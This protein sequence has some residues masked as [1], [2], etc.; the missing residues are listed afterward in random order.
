MAEK[1]YLWKRES[2]GTELL[3][4]SIENPSQGIINPVYNENEGRYGASYVRD[5]LSNVEMLYSSK[6]RVD[7]NKKLGNWIKIYYDGEGDNSENYSI[8]GVSDDF[9]LEN[10]IPS[11]GAKY[12]FVF[13]DNR[14]QEMIVGQTYEEY[15]FT[16]TPFNGVWEGTSAGSNSHVIKPSNSSHN[17]RVHY[18]ENETYSIWVVWK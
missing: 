15:G 4:L 14:T 18:N 1:A 17:V 7:Y 2:D 10:N 11:D 5:P 3:T 13:S 8:M 6:G 9:S 16:D 12:I